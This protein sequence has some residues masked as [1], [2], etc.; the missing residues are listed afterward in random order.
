MNIPNDNNNNQTRYESYFWENNARKGS[1][2]HEY[3]YDNNNNNKTMAIYYKLVVNNNWIEDYKS[4]H[5]YD[6]K[7]NQTIEDGDLLQGVWA[8]SEEENAA[9]IID[10]KENYFRNSHNIE[11]GE[12]IGTNHPLRKTRCHRNRRWQFMGKCFQ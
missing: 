8:E 9:F 1:Q 5:E 11:Y 6:D 10:G 2:K 3:A 7:G 12:C 4:E